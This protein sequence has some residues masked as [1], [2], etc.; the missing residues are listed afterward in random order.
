MVYLECD[1]DKKEAVIEEPDDGPETTW[2]TRLEVVSMVVDGGE[3]KTA[4]QVERQ[5][6]AEHQQLYSISTNT[7]TTLDDAVAS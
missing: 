7:T 4:C 2:K 1:E 3:V 5:R 6:N